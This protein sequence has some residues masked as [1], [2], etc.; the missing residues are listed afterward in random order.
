[1]PDETDEILIMA[2]VDRELPPD[3]RAAVERRLAESDEL[4]ALEQEMRES[5]ELLAQAFAAE[6][7]RPVPESLQRMIAEADIEDRDPAEPN[8]VS[9]SDFMKRPDFRE[10][11]RFA[12]VAACLL[13]AI[14]LGFGGLV[15]PLLDDG[16]AGPVASA[17]LLAAADPNTHAA[18]NRTV[19]GEVV[20][21][22]SAEGKAS[23]R[24]MP[25]ATFQSEAGQY[26]RQFTQEV[27]GSDGSTRLLAIACRTGEGAW[28][29]TFA[30]V[31]GGSGSPNSETYVTASGPSEEAFAKAAAAI[32]TAP[33]LDPAAERVLLDQWSRK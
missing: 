1:M 30:M 3:Q 14:G 12:A 7:D 24:I 22:R 21:W 18:L 33:A 13:L 31:A 32:G 17:D 15:G 11:R 16:A 29:T 26:C 28:S 5:R 8:V 9:F 27:A 20:A 19:S 4:R 23:G 6:A 2:Y 10:V 25:I